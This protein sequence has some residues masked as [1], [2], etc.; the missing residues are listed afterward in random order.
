MVIMAKRDYIKGDFQTVLGTDGEIGTKQKSKQDWL[1]LDEGNPGFQLDRNKLLQTYFMCSSALT[2]LSSIYLFPNISPNHCSLQGCLQRMVWET[3]CHRCTI[4]PTIKQMHTLSAYIH[5]KAVI[6]G[7][8]L[9]LS[10]AK[11]G[12]SSPQLENMDKTIHLA[13]TD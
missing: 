9:V 1:E 10:D 12:T 13:K 2:V 3:C 7:N 6:E 5:N 11:Q 8:G 4:K